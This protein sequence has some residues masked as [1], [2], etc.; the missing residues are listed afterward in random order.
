MS[1]KSEV[2]DAWD[3]DWES[4]ADVRADGRL[5]ALHAWAHAASQKREI[6]PRNETPEPPV[7]LSKAA[8]K[9]QHV[10]SNK[11]LWDAA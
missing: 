5:F 9:A 1:G 3:D 7:R 11:Q 6:S 10:E 8:R 2:P 4:M